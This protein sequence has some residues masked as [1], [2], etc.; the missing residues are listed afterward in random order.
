MDRKCGE[1]FTT[2]DRSLSG[3]VIIIVIIIIIIFL[4]RI[5]ILIF[6]L[7]IIVALC[8]ATNRTKI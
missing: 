2:D 6:I 7:I 5:L 3:I 1:R 8:G 4:I